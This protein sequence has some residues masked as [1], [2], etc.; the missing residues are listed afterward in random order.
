VSASAKLFI[1]RDYDRIADSL[2]S[3]LHFSLKAIETEGT[4]ELEFPLDRYRI[5]LL[6]QRRN[7][8]DIN[9][10]MNSKSSTLD[11]GSGFTSANPIPKLLPTALDFEIPSQ[12]SVKCRSVIEKRYGRMD[13]NHQPLPHRP[14]ARSNGSARSIR[15]AP[16]SRQHGHTLL[17]ESVT[18]FSRRDGSENDNPPAKSAQERFFKPHFNLPFIAVAC[19]GFTQ[20]L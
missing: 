19:T 10:R 7:G 20:N 18:E 13:L 11:L 4:S 16:L 6:E 3:H 2:V 15:A 17:I 5:E 1:G 12:T 9:L 14:M 8:G